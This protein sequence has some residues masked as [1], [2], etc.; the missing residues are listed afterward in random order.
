MSLYDQVMTEA[1]RSRSDWSE[2]PP[3][4]PSSPWRAERV[5]KQERE[6]AEIAKAK[7]KPLVDPKKGTP[8]A[9]VRGVIRDIRLGKYPKVGRGFEGA[10]A[11]PAWVRSVRRA[12]R[13]HLDTGEYANVMERGLYVPLTLLMI[14]GIN[15]NETPE[16]TAARREASKRRIFGARPVPVSREERLTKLRKEA[17]VLRKKAGEQSVDTSKA[18]V[19][20][21]FRTVDLGNIARRIGDQK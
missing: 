5:K 15:P 7:T 2:W 1:K 11:G 20:R 21:T 3:H 10:K 18:R 19:R 17:D 16:Q 6:D 8:R 12:S 14:E 13:Q 4:R 9:A